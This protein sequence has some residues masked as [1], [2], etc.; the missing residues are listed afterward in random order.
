MIIRTCKGRQTELGI[1]W[2]DYKKA[3][4][5]VPHPWIKK[6]L[7][8]FGV[9]ENIKG[10]LNESIEKW[11]TDL[12]SGGNQFRQSENEKGNISRRQLVT[13]VV[14]TGS[15]TLDNGSAKS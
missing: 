3:Y 8:V 13:I 5:M 15:N 6:C 1:A 7:T 4:D 12:T 10:V 14:C 9:E 2:I 11:C